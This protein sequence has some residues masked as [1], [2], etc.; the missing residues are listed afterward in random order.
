M[1]FP[2]TLRP[3]GK[4][5]VTEDSIKWWRSVQP[6][7]KAGMKESDWKVGMQYPSLCHTRQLDNG[8]QDKHNWLHWPMPYSYGSKMLIFPSVCAYLNNTIFP[9]CSQICHKFSLTSCA[10]P[11]QKPLIPL[12]YLVQRPMNAQIS[13]FNPVYKVEDMRT[14]QVVICCWCLGQK[15]WR[16]CCMFTKGLQNTAS[17]SIK[18]NAESSFIAST[19]W[20]LQEQF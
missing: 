4:V 14:E 9:L 2:L 19:Q 20:L 11:L 5:K 6:T 17:I 7:S 1:C 16:D 18:K 13:I 12:S 10:K 3:S 8:Q 15:Y